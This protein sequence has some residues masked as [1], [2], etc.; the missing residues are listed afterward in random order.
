M[1][2]RAVVAFQLQSSARVPLATNLAWLCVSATCP[3]AEFW[4]A[5]AFDHG[6]IGIKAFHGNLF[7]GYQLAR[8]DRSMQM[9]HEIRKLVRFQRGLLPSGVRN[10]HRLTSMRL[11]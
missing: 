2:A 7:V 5:K 1:V 8:I 4:R 9:T 10:Q 11:I 3:S 6:S